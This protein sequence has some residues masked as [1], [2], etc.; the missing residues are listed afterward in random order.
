MAYS[1][2]SE[3]TRLKARLKERAA[4]ALTAHLLVPALLGLLGFC[5]VA[6]AVAS[7]NGVLG[8]TVTGSAVV[9]TLLLAAGAA[10]YYVP[11]LLA[12]QWQ[13]PLGV[14]AAV[15]VFHLLLFATVG[16]SVLLTVQAVPVALAGGG[17]LLAT[18]LWSQFRHG[19]APEPVIGPAPESDSRP[20]THTLVMVAVNWVFFAAAGMFSGWFLLGR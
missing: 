15:T 10:P 11:V 17:L 8:I 12:G 5:A 2:Q 3:R 13:K 16:R 14:L 4:P 7:T 18:S 19:P 6:A 20:F 1:G 9:A